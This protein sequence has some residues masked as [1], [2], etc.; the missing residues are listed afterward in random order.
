MGEANNVARPQD[1]KNKEET[2]AVRNE[3]GTGPYIVTSR[4]PDSR[5]VMKLNDAYW[6]KGQFPL[7]ATDVVYSVIASGPTRVAALLSGE[8]DF[9]Q[10]MPVQDI[11]RVAQTPASR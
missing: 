4:E 7:Q 11:D 1:F 8:V 3:N 6:G 5:T 2:F 10:D 9:V